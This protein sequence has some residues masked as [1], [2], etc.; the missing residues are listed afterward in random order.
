MKY[1]VCAKYC[2]E[3]IGLDEFERESDAIEFAKH[4]F[5]LFDKDE[6]AELEEDEII[7]PNEMWIEKT[8]E[9][10]IEYPDFSDIIDDDLPF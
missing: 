8:E 5:V 10:K 3:T 6:A 2:G 4:P 1:I 9:R 7:Y